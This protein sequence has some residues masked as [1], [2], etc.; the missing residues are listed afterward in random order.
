M[1]DYTIKIRDAVIENKNFRGI[2]KQYNAAGSRN[3][4]V[5]LSPNQEIA[6]EEKENG[7]INSYIGTVQDL[8]K[9]GWNIRAH[10]SYNDE[11]GT[12]EEDG[13]YILSSVKISFR[14]PKYQPCIRYYPSA[15]AKTFVIMTE[16]LLDPNGAYG[17]VLDDRY[18]PFAHCDL[19]IHGY[20]DA[21]GHV[22][23]YVQNMAIVGVPTFFDEFGYDDGGGQF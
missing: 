20:N 3:F 9:Q 23:A 12:W 4:T 22:S 14:N 10:K 19:S 21:P 17:A 18:R 7:V 1:S 6:F 13:N 11:T 8:I 2:E 5:T 15:D 16:E